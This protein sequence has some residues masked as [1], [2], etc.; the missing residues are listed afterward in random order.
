ML[1]SKRQHKCKASS[2][3][4]ARVERSVWDNK[5]ASTIYLESGLKKC[6]AKQ[7]E[8]KVERA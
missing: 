7:G 8:P 2:K 5:R 4:T 1:N 6:V 3:R